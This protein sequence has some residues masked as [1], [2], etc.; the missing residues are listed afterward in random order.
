MATCFTFLILPHIHLMDLAGPD[1]TIHEAMDYGADFKIQYCGIDEEI[2]STAG[3]DI[4]QPVHYSKIQM[5]KGDYLVIPGSKLDYIISEEFKSNKNLFSWLKKIHAE[6]INLVSICA[7]AFVLAETGLLNGLSATTHFKQTSNLQK[8]YPLV[9]VKENILF[10]EENGIY[11][12][13]GIAS[14]IDLMLHIIEKEK[15]SY[16]AHKVAR[17]LVIYSR[18]EGGNKQASAFMEF[19]NHIHAGIHKVQDHIIEHI[20]EKHYLIQLA[21]LANMS[22]RNF[23]RTFKSETGVTVVQYINSIRKEVAENLL[24][25][26]DLS[27]QQIAKKVGLE[28]EKQVRRILQDAKEL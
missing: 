15:D 9:N 5:N 14:G 28:S 7:G 16:F 2:K 1:Q 4:K 22:E 13:A 18:R 11:T 27:Y 20:N 26:K 23:T 19:R 3:L 8:M 6:G 17:E 24:K 10:V 12:S 25:N 21:E